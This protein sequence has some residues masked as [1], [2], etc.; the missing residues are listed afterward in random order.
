MMSRAAK[1]HLAGRLFETPALNPQAKAE[2]SSQN[3]FFR[4][5]PFQ[6]LSYKSEKLV[7]LK[8]QRETGDGD[9]ECSTD[10]NSTL[11]K[12]LLLNTYRKRVFNHEKLVFFKYP[13]V[14]SLVALEK[15]LLQK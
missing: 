2:K 7:K 10:L 13:S 4:Y 12:W 6:K 9:I 5:S 14:G 11:L 8:K 3:T 1:T 15:L